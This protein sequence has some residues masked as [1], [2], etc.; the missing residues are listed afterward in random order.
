MD[1]TDEIKRALRSVSKS[2]LDFV[3]QAVQDP[4]FYDRAEFKELDVHDWAT[5]AAIQS[6]PTFID[7]PAIEE[8]TRV[9]V[10]LCHIVK[11]IP[12]VIFGFDVDLMSEFYLLN[13]DFLRY[14]IMGG[15]EAL[16]QTLTGAVGRGDFLVTPEGLWCVE[17][18]IASNL[19]GIW[20]TTTWERKMTSVPVIAEY[21]SRN[22]LNVKI[23]NTLRMMMQ[24]I[25]ENA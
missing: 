10:G 5:E 1:L 9:A 15:E 14:V 19:G 18:N 16:Q 4:R 6:W 13:A 24:H 11:R 21:L 17:F 7:T 12:E 3:Q 23:R 2:H 22:H 8:M 25:V 20:E